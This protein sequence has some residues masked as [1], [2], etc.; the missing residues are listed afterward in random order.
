[1][2]TDYIEVLDPTGDTAQL[3]LKPL[4]YFLL[5]ILPL[6][7]SYFTPTSTFLP[8]NLMF[9]VLFLSL[10]VWWTILSTKFHFLFFYLIP[11]PLHLFKCTNLSL[12]GLSDA[13]LKVF[14]LV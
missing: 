1:M 9:Y 4:L 6:F 7:K 14:A 3:D 12:T 8:F 10:L 2:E 11:L 5:H 13:Q